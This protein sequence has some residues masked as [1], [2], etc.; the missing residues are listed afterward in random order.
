MDQKSSTLQKEKRSPHQQRPGQYEIYDEIVSQQ[1]N[2]AKKKVHYKKVYPTNKQFLPEA[3]FQIPESDRNKYLAPY[4][5]DD[6]HRLP[7]EHEKQPVSQFQDTAD[8]NYFPNN[9]SH[10]KDKAPSRNRRPESPK[11]EPVKSFERETKDVCYDPSLPAV[12]YRDP[13]LASSSENPD[14]DLGKHSSLICRAINYD[15]EPVTVNDQVIRNKLILS[16]RPRRYYGTESFSKKP[17]PVQNDRSGYGYP[18]TNT[19]GYEDVTFHRSTDIEY[20]QKISGQP[21]PDTRPYTEKRTYTGSGK[22]ILARA[23]A[24]DLGSLGLGE[25][26]IQGEKRPEDQ[27]KDNDK[28]GE[29]YEEQYRV[30]QCKRY[31]RNFKTL[32]WALF[33]I[34]TLLVLVGLALLLLTMIH[35]LFRNHI[36]IVIG[37]TGFVNWVWGAMALSLCIIIVGVYGIITSITR[38]K[39]MLVAYCIAAAILA[40]VILIYLLIFWLMFS[41]L[42]DTERYSMVSTFNKYR[43]QRW[44]RQGWDT[45]QEKYQCCGV[46]ARGDWKYV[47]PSCCH[48][49][50]KFQK[51]A[52]INHFIQE[53]QAYSGGCRTKLE[54]YFTSMFLLISCLLVLAIILLILGI[55]AA[56]RLLK[57]YKIIL[58]CREMYLITP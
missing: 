15:G 50:N 40:L 26:G 34:N 24:Y 28:E 45:V 22:P 51:L 9:L 43:C 11:T 1:R 6:Y 21:Y 8:P 57:M 30:I 27:I 53:D 23:D 16:C 18:P 52:C 48:A 35:F 49:D 33:I 13:N 38:A 7:K 58:M 19:S 2:L 3:H 39:P 46:E 25:H 41:N 17:V 29:K 56:L 55:M 4:P 54:D 12:Q 32:L 37:Q 42:K 20:Q 14:G 5:S 47:P 31:T 10:Y 44:I 36:N